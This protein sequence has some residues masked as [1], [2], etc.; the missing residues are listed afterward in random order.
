[1]KMLDY[2]N[3]FLQDCNKIKNSKNCKKKQLNMINSK[4]GLKK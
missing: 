1:M 4:M 2:H 3:K